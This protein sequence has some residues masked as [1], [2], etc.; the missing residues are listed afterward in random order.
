MSVAFQKQLPSPARSARKRASG[1]TIW[2]W[3]RMRASPFFFFFSAAPLPPREPSRGPHIADFIRTRT[4]SP[5]SPDLCA[6]APPREPLLRGLCEPFALKIRRKFATPAPFLPPPIDSKSTSKY[7]GTQPEQ[8]ERA[9]MTSAT[10]ENDTKSDARPKRAQPDRP[11]DKLT[12]EQRERAN[13]QLEEME[14]IK[15]FP[16]SN[17]AAP[18]EWQDPAQMHRRSFLPNRHAAM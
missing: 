6:S 17:V 11:T 10:Y 5:R 13:R 1:M 12:A 8:I 2:F 7:Q 9:I 4:K 3:A 15:S 14:R 16:K 18:F